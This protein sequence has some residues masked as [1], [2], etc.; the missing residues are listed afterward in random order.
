MAEISGKREKRV[1]VIGGWLNK[2]FMAPFSFMGSCTKEV[3]NAWLE[4]ILLPE[5]PAG[6]TVVMDNATFHKSAKTRELIE[7]KDCRLLYLPPYSPDLNPI[8]H[9]WH[10]LKSLVRPLLP[11]WENPVRQLVDQCLL[12]M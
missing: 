10:K 7:G 6:T 3:F 2:K 5:L 9:L 11:A 4:E 12:N 1:S 8:E